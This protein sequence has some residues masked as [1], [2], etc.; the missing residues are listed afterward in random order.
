MKNI[1]YIFFVALGGDKSTLFSLLTVNNAINQKT[2]TH[3][4]SNRRKHS[5]SAKL[6]GDKSPK[7][8][9]PNLNY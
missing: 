7:H 1:Y 5:L 3:L 9:F 8:T 2:P 6:L 4:Y